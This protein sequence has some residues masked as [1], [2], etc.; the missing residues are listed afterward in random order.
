MTSKE[1]LTKL[2]IQLHKRKRR[3]KKEII[4]G[5]E[6]YEKIYEDLKILE[7]IKKHY[8]KNSLFVTMGTA[9]S[10][11]IDKSDP[12]F[13]KVKEWLEDEKE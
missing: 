8:D 2:Y 4:D 12:D 10:F 1:A 5:H 3:T 6:Q 11:W 9:L 7:I 13:E